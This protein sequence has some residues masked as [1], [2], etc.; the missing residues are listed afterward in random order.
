M[1]PI[2][3]N[4]TF[5]EYIKNLPKWESTSLKNLNIHGRTSNEILQLCVNSKICVV[6]DWSSENLKGTYAW[7]LATDADEITIDCIG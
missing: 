7:V 4:R 5:E 6:S 1:P 3:P 2:V